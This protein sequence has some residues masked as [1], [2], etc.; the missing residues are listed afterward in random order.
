MPYFCPACKARVPEDGDSI[1]CDYCRK[2]HHLKYTDLSP[3]QFEIYARDKSFEWVCN[4][5]VA[6]TCHKC[7]ILTK[8]CSKI[9][10][11]R[12][13]QK[14]HLRCAGL[15]KTAYI[16]TTL[17]YCYQCQEE[18][19]PF[20]NVTIR[21]FF[22]LSFNSLN[23]TNHPNQ[24]RTLHSSYSNNLDLEYSTKCN[25]CCKKVDCTNSAIPCQS[26]NCLT[27]KSCSN[28]RQNDIDY[29]RNNTN[30]W[31]CQ[32][33]L[34]DKFPFMITEDIDI[35][36]DSFNSDWSC[37]CKTKT[38]GRGPIGPDLTWGR[39]PHTHT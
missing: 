25:V 39:K 4:Y 27:H 14:Y 10:C 29:F 1:S 32:T 3:A 11:E 5:C 8:D 13:E 34:K 2:W 33:C 23:L 36:M 26:C 28:L 7:N 35:H 22:A 12:C 37:K 18:I 6:N 17:W 20:S 24:L 30:A 31:E 21:Q 15:S 9:Q 19:F 16:P 38:Q